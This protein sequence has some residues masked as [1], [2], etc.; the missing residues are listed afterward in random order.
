MGSPAPTMSR[1]SPSGIGIRPGSINPNLFQD[2]FYKFGSF[3]N[4]DA[5][6]RR[7]RAGRTCTTASRSRG[8]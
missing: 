7:Q 1:G 5:E 6:V 3:G 8:A 4:P 2:Q